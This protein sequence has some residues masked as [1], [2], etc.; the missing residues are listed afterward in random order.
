[1]FDPILVNLLKTRPHYGHSSRENATPSSGT[2]LLASCQGVP[3]PPRDRS[4][5]FSAVEPPLTGHLGSTT[6]TFFR[7]T[8]HTLTLV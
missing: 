7:G 2:S 6:A 3:P 5:Y 1:M 4:P 8:I